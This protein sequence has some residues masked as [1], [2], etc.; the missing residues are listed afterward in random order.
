MDF[1]FLSARYFYISINIL[2]LC[3]E[4]QLGYLEAVDSLGSPK[5][6]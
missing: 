3:V 6:C 1:T 5:F 4:M 2:E